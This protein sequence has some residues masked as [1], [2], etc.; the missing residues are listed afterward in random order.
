[1]PNSDEKFQI[2]AIGRVFKALKV[3]FTVM[4]KLAGINCGTCA[5]CLFVPTII[6]NISYLLQST[7][8][9]SDAKIAHNLY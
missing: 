5:I 8:I 1:M 9:Q 4:N 7:V 6:N 2:K 3:Y